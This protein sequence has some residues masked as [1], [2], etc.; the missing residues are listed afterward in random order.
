MSG[1]GRQS[2]KDCRLAYED[3]N[4]PGPR[5]KHQPSEKKEPPCATCQPLIIPEN[6][7]AVAAYFRSSDQWILAP[8]GYR[9]GLLVPS[10]EAVLRMMRVSEQLATFDKVMRIGAE[11]CAVLAKE[12]EKTNG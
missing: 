8:N 5:R 9:L 4:R 1:V 10:V 6:M 7:E 11:V 12:A 2:C 3:H